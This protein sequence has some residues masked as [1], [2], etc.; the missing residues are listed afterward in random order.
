MKLKILKSALKYSLAANDQKKTSD[1]FSKKALKD[2]QMIAHYVAQ[3]QGLM[4]SLT[5][6]LKAIEDDEDLERGDIMEMMKDYIDNL[7][8]EV[9]QYYNPQDMN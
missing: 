3:L 4:V 6:L 2:P 8:D 7:I 5:F 9:K 1:S